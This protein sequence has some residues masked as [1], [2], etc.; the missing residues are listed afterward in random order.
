MPT[1]YPQEKSALY[2]LIKSKDK[3]VC[4]ND[5]DKNL[6]VANTGRESII[7]EGGDKYMIQLHTTNCQN[8][9]CEIL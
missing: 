9:K 7:G 3:E 1:L 2:K 5:T 4:I 8:K 6:G